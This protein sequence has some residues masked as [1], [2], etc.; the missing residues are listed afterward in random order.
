[1]WGFSDTFWPISFGKPGLGGKIQD[2]IVRF[3]FAFAGIAT[4]TDPIDRV[5]HV[6]SESSIF[7][8]YRV[9][10]ILALRYGF[11][12]LSKTFPFSINVIFR[13]SPESFQSSIISRLGEI[14][15]ENVNR[16][17]SH[18]WDSPKLDNDTWCQTDHRPLIKFQRSGREFY[19][20]PSVTSGPHPNTRP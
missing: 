15:V 13:V 17:V 16:L 11:A 19:W 5:A 7:V 14:H 2:S 6:E 12:L 3:L 1:M 10:G 20:S 9:Y 4:W 8:A 18:F